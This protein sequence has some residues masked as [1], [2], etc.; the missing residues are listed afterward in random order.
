MQEHSPGVNYQEVKIYQTTISTIS[1]HCHCRQESRLSSFKRRRS[2]KKTAK[3]KQQVCTLLRLEFIAFKF[4]FL[5]CFTSPLCTDK[6]ALQADTYK[7][8]AWIN[9]H[10]IIWPY[11]SVRALGKSFTTVRGFTRRTW[12]SN[13]GSASWQTSTVCIQQ[14]C[15]QKARRGR[16]K[17]RSRESL[18]VSLECRHVPNYETINNTVSKYP[19]ALC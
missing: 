8:A 13:H 3:S 4:F 6:P 11:D 2:A 18:K 9:C 12:P 14:L 15:F 17:A 19:S 7:Q 10:K 16:F 1:T 5:F